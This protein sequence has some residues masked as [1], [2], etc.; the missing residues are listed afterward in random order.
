MCSIMNNGV[1]KNCTCKLAHLCKSRRK[2][3]TAG[4]SLQH[5]ISKLFGKTPVLS[6]LIFNQAL[7]ANHI[8]A[9]EGHHI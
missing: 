2:L 8:H 9:K 3:E 5:D 7:T 4:E 6:P 1:T